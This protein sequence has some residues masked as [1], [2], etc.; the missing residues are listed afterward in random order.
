MPKSTHSKDRRPRAPSQHADRRAAL[1]AV[2][3]EFDQKVAALQAAD[4]RERVE[5]ALATRGKVRMR[6]KA[7]PS[8]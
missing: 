8:F 1:E 7:D 3:A 5:A 6:S 4:L 2:S